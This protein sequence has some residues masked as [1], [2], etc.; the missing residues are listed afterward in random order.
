MCFTTLLLEEL[1]VLLKFHFLLLSF[2]FTVI[3]LRI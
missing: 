3:I 1:P 2:L